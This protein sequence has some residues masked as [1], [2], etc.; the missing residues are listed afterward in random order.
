MTQHSG[1]TITGLVETVDRIAARAA[2]DELGTDASLVELEKRGNEIKAELI[3]KKSMP[4]GGD[5]FRFLNEDAP[6]EPDFDDDRE[7]L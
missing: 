6:D 3:A 2:I 1:D 7:E 4:T 5:W